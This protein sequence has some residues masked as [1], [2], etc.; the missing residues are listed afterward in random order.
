MSEVSFS[1]LVGIVRW[2]IFAM[3][4][5]PVIVKRLHAL[6]WIVPNV[7]FPQPVEGEDLL[8]SQPSCGAR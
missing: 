2:A 1:G 4:G 3:G 5:D 7:T 6:V 8:C